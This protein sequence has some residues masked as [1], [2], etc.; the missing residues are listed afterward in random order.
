MVLVSVADLEAAVAR[1]VVRGE[2]GRI[3]RLR[4]VVAREE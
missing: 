3:G 2:A 4:I 1:Q